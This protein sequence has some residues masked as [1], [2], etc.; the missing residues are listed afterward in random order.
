[1]LASAMLH[2]L[3]GRLPLHSILCCALG[4]NVK[5]LSWSCAALRDFAAVLI[6]VV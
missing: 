1:M 3:R 4:Y 2:N 6:G 5:G